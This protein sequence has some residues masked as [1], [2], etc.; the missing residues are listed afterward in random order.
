MN[1]PISGGSQLVLYADDILLYWPISRQED[2]ALLQRNIDSG[3]SDNCLQFNVINKK[4]TSE[5]ENTKD[6]FAVAVVHLSQTV[7]GHVPRTIA[8]A[9][10]L[11]LARKGTIQCKVTG[12][13]CFVIDFRIYYPVCVHAY[14][15]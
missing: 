10:A 13:R 8:A 11:F 7:V 5:I 9:C 3:V 6:P 14:Y 2:Y 1:L 4:C 15:P 12:N